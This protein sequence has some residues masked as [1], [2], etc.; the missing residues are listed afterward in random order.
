MPIKPDFDALGL[1]P[2]D[3]GIVEMRLAKAKAV[4]SVLARVQA[5]AQGLNANQTRKISS[6]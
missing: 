1:K 3:R 6:L 4:P 2:M 5:G